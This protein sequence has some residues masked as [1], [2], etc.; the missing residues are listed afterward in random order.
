MYLYAN[1]SPFPPSFEGNPFAYG[2]GLF[3]DVV[4]AAL[5]LMMLLTYVYEARRGRQINAITATQVTNYA[6]GRWSALNIYRGLISSLLTFVVLRA[7]PD[8]VWM[9]AWGEVSEPT[10]RHML[11]VDLLMDGVAVVPLLAAVLCW[12]WGR[13][14]IPHLLVEE[15][16]AG[17]IG[18]PPGD[19]LWKNGRVVLVVLLI[20][21][22]VTIGKA[23][24]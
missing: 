21:I 6:H 11:T 12:C 14:V 1:P 9:L 10:I 4:A 18:G 5:A 3:G 13:Q 20:A 17:V 24:A 23:T 2:F 7:L 8:A 15:L 16:R 19:I 22:G